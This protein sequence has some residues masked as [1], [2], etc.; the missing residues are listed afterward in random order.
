MRPGGVEVELEQDECPAPP[1][2][3][4]RPTKDDELRLSE[5][6]VEVA[7]ALF[8][9]DGYGATSVE[10]VARA[11]RISKRTFYHRFADKAAL[12]AAVVHRIVAGLR[13][14][15]NV[16]IFEGANTEAVLHHIARMMVHATVEPTALALHRMI[17]S[18]AIRFPELAAAVTAEGSRAEAIA[19]ISGI[20]SREAA[21]GRFDV[22]DPELAAEQ[23][24]QLVIAAPQR[25]ALGL[26]NAMTMD[27]R[28]KWAEAAV[29][30]FLNGCRAPS[31]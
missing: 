20:L 16:P 31:L 11:A 10:A 21:T 6:I 26:G 5:K 23:F 9:K 19:G 2:R 24:I 18:E 8:L 17:V 27:E 25:R 15:P 7:T 3:G 4:G 1:R 22:A 28:E 14:P 12:F 30:L 29:R 13:P